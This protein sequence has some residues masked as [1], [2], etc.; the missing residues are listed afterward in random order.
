ML[1]AEEIFRVENLHNDYFH[2]Y[3]NTK[4]AWSLESGYESN[5]TAESYPFR[6][7]VHDFDLTLLTDVRDIDRRCRGPVQGFQIWLHNPAELPH[8]S[9]NF[10]RLSLKYQ[11]NV[12]VKPILTKTSHYLVDYSPLKR[13]CY[14][15]KERYL[16]YFRTY[17]ESNCRLEC[18]ANY[19]IKQ[20]DCV[21][22]YLPHGPNTKICG[23]GKSQCI[24]E[25]LE[26]LSL[27]NSKLDVTANEK[28]K[29]CGCPKACTELKYITEVS[30]DIY[31][32]ATMGKL[33]NPDNP[34]GR[35]VPSGLTIKLAKE[36][37]TSMRRS[38]LYS[39]V[40]FLAHCG[41]IMGLFIGFSILSLMEI[42]FYFTLRL[43]CV[44]VKND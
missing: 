39:T 19:T 27:A 29:A 25:A 26:E 6:G 9:Q 42:V 31:D 10:F 35:R 5:S 21:P 33:F 30:Q 18:A 44:I 14:F 16:K 2:T 3:G 13:R 32:I 4:S 41:G 28:N 1:S 22:S 24:I 34:Q 43:W 11:S 36:K 8:M 38:E 15:S 12:I 20:C 23:G 17:T 7:L 37:F 40:E